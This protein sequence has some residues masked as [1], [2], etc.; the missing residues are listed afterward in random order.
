M[1]RYSV[2]VAILATALLSG[3]LFLSSAQ[4]TANAI[5]ITVYKNPTCGCCKNWIKHMEANGFAVKSVDVADISPYKSK[6]GITPSLA[7]CHTAVINGY[8]VE[9]HVPAGD[10][11]RMLK[12]RPGIQG[13]AVPGMPSG[14]PGMEQGYQDPYD[15]LTF[16]K[17]GNLSVYSR[18][19]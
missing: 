17:T 5:E 2:S 1:N 10:I 7:S 13:L 6:Y 11:K 14:S 9:G 16:D 3:W 4:T 18:H 12:E 8:V 15:V 19:P